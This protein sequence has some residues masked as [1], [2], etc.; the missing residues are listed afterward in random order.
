MSYTIARYVN[1]ETGG[2]NEHLLVLKE[3]PMTT[4]KDLT[5][6]FNE[7]CGKE[8]LDWVSDLVRQSRGEASNMRSPYKSLQAMYGVGLTD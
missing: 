6:L 5:E 4:G 7:V 2:D 1:E 8:C 3:S